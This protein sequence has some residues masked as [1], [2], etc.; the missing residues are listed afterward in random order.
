MAVQITPAIE[1]QL[2]HLAASQERSLDEVANEAILG[3]LESQASLAA[4]IREAEEVA[5]R[6]GW[7]EHDEVVRR[8]N[9]RLA[10][11]A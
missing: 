5:E 10:K 2:Q 8:I 9:E 4:D 1:Q 6:D 3:Y 7:I 11:F